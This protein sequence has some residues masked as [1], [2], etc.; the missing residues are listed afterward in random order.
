MLKSLQKIVYTCPKQ[1]RKELDFF[2]K[3]SFMGH[4][5]EF[6]K[7]RAIPKYLGQHS[8]ILTSK[9]AFHNVCPHRGTT[10][11]DNPTSKK[12]LVC[13]Y[14]SWSFTLDGASKKAPIKTCLQSIPTT[15]RHGFRISGNSNDQ[16]DSAWK[17][18][19][20]MDWPNLKIHQTK[21]W[22]AK[23]NW[24]LL[25]ENFLEWYHLPAVHPA[26]TKI[27]KPSE[28]VYGIVDDW[29]IGFK[30]DPLT[31]AG[32][33]ADPSFVPHI[34]GAH[35]TAAL[36]HYLFPNMF[37]FVLPT[38]VFIVTLVPIGPTKTI[39][40]AMLLV[41]PDSEWPNDSLEELWDFYDNVNTEDVDICEKMQKGIRS[42]AFQHGW[43]EEKSEKNIFYFHNQLKKHNLI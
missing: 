33:P 38:H 11:M 8:T 17:Q 37:W 6:Q 23:A 41:H 22:V 39:E 30:T 26:L 32:L 29:A 3:T 35:P 19:G 28:H 42:N 34:P 16:W 12:L 5:A 31:E 43:I 21:T 4:I 24:K 13:P 10:L 1:F 27:S 14:H 15:T 36:F 18:V 7:H 2:S 20:G 25:I 40:N 9:D